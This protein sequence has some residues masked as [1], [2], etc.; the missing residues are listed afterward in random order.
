MT[1]QRKR[2]TMPRMNV[3]RD[4]KSSNPAF[5]RYVVRIV[6][7]PPL[8]ASDLLPNTVVIKIKNSAMRSNTTNRILLKIITG[9]T[10]LE[11][12]HCT[13]CEANGIYS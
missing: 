3:M 5:P 9:K 4:M 8:I 11:R 10:S 1:R 12:P 13:W 2:K 6:E 7:L